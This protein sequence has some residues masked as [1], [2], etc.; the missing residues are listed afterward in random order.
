MQFLPK[1]VQSP[2]IPVWVVGAWPRKKSMR[3][4]LRWDGILP[5]VLPVGSSPSQADPEEVGRKIVEDGASTG[6]APQD[7]TA[8]SG[9]VRRE[10]GDGPFD[11]VIEG[12][13]SGSRREQAA[14][15]VGE[16]AEAGATWWIEAVWTWLYLPPQDVD[17]MRRRIRQGPPRI[18]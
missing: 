2:R 9:Y 16:Y 6:I 15:K 14:S 1:P 18:D 17:R 12:N 5:I 13:S 11:V 8:I 3:R 10:R 4:T 7:I